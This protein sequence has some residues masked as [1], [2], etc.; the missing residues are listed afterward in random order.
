[1]PDSQTSPDADASPEKTGGRGRTA[2]T[3]SMSLRWLVSLALPLLLHLILGREGARL[4]LEPMAALFLSLTFWAVCAWMLGTMNDTAVAIALPLLY[5]LICGAEQKVVLSPWLGDVPTVVI[6]GLILGKIVAATGLGRRIALGC[7]RRTGGSLVGAILG[8]SLGAAILAPLVPSIMGKAAIFTVIAVALCDALGLKPKS[9]EATAVLLATCCALGATKLCYLTGAADMTLGMD[10]VDGV[11][12]IRTT[13]VGYA[14]QN[15]VPGM[16]YLVL[17]VAVVLLA[18]RVRVPT[19]RVREA[20]ARAESGPLTG[21]QRKALGLLLLT[22]LLLATDSMHDLSAGSV[23]LLAACASFLPGL[24]LM[25]GRRLAGIDFAPLLFVM[26]CMSI[27]AAGESLGATQ[28]LAGIVFPALEGMGETAA[29]VSAYVAGVLLNFLLTPLAATS[30]FTVPITELGLALNVEPRVLYLAFQ[31]GLDNLFFPY[32][33]AL[34]LYFYSSG[35]VSLRLMVLVLGLRMIAT[36]FFV[37]LVAIP[38]W[39]FVM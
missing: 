31:Y 10:L 39:D 21:E 37:W 27:S 13:W 12:G 24:G 5:V 30:A 20:V 18:L 19:R 7:A 14:A 8:L 16:L 32:E 11:M 36:G 1:M 9:R 4:G 3:F 2:A 28:W 26:G 33:Y 35:Y 29:G 38:W 25:D 34:Y 6:G 17:S 15:F 23:L 22:I